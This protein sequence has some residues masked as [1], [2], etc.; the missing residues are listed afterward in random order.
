MG[1]GWKIGRLAGIDLAVHPSWLVIAFLLTF[2]LAD[3]FFPRLI[4][5]WSTGQYWLLGV[6]T[7]FLFFASVLAHEFS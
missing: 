7:A 5:G 2:S 1:S 4:P 3:A 6:G